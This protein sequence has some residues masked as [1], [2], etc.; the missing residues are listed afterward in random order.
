MVDNDGKSWKRLVMVVRGHYYDLG[1]DDGH[2]R[3]IYVYIYI[4]L[5]PRDMLY[6][7]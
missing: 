5:Y 4:Y 7:N 6:I 1:E 2:I 3:C